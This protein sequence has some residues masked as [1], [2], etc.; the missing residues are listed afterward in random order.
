MALKGGYILHLDATYEDKSPLLMIGLDSIMQIVLGNIKLSTEKSDDIVPFLRDIRDLFGEPLALVHD[1]SKGILKAIS[2]VFPNIL[3]FICHFHFLRDIGKDLLGQQYDNIR[4]ALKKHGISSKL[5]GRL[6]SLKQIVDENLQLIDML[7]GSLQN[8][9]CC[10]KSL[11]HMPVLAAYSLIDWALNGQ[12]QGN[13]YG[14]PFD[15]P[16]LILA[17]R[18]KIIYTELDQLRKIQLSK[19]HRDNEPLH[20][21][22]FELVNIINDK[23]LWQSVEIIESEIKIF[24]NLREAMRIAPKSGKQGLNHNGIPCDIRTIEQRVK[25]FR[26]EIV[27][28]KEY[29][30]NIK[31]QK[32]IDQIDKYWKKL[33]ADPIEIDTS[34]GKRQIQP[35]RTNN[36]VEREIRDL[37]RGY[38]QKTGNHSLGK[39][40]RTMLANTPLV[41]NLRNDEY[42]STLLNGRSGLEEL[43][44]E[45]D[46]TEVRGELRKSQCNP[47]KIPAKLKKL[48]TEKTFPERLRKSFI[49]LK[50]NGILC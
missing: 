3:D 20:K 38:R 25:S 33:F 26:N 10:E 28:E 17:Q 5:K 27:S 41:K 1:M 30:K 22:F 4:K 34:E 11:K 19:D 47:A 44:A 37:K 50:S 9:P 8:H 7:G 23:T 39:T 48:T 12:N 13:G 36:F 42:L 15:C 18:L 40:L 2:Q 35:Q 31:H 21:L 24:E 45:I 6:R 49:N 16:H 46:I 29:S 43:F 14:F 32:M